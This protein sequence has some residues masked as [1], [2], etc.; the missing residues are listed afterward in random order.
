[1]NTEILNKVEEGY[2]KD[3]LPEVNVGDTVEVS[4]II[5]EGDRKRIQRFTGLIIAKKGSG[6]RLMI[7]VRKISYG[8]GVEKIFPVH[9]KNVQEIVV[10][11]HGKVRRSKLYFM[12]DRV[13]KRAMKVKKGKPVVVSEGA[14]NANEEVP[15]TEDVVEENSTDEEKADN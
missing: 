14:V 9:S 4:T 1:M 5:R 7:T 2:L 11:Q 13:G 3:D 6:A 10:L 8:V 15:S 12:R